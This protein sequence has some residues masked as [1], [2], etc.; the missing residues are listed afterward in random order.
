MTPLAGVA[1]ALV[2]RARIDQ[3]A[4]IYASWTRT[5]ASMLLGAALLA[6]AMGS[7][8]PPAL[9]AGWFGLMLLNQLWRWRLTI[10]WRRARPGPAAIP[11]WGGYWAVGS[12]IAGALWGL[13]AVTMFPASPAHQALLI[14]CLFGVVLGGLNLTAV[15]RPSFYAFVL[16]ALVPLIARVAWEGDSVHLY[17]ALVMAVVLGFA[18]LLPDEDSAVAERADALLG[19]CRGFLGGFGLSAGAE[20]PLSPEASEALDDM[21]KIAA[22]RLSYDDPEGDEAALVE[23]AEFV[24]VA[25]L[26]LYGDCVGLPQ[27]RRRLH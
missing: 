19:W 16:P 18:L 5:T 1:P 25:A 9:F 11:R 23:V 27:A 14:V 21:S 7:V 3:V 24:R 2:A 6:I 22:S 12:G 13:S 8:V 17:T 20:P 10:A 26:L 4:T 15:W